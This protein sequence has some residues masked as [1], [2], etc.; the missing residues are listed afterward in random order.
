MGGGGC[1]SEPVSPFG[2]GRGHGG[3][4]AWGTWERRRTWGA[5]VQGDTGTRGHRGRRP[6]GHPP[7]G[8]RRHPPTGGSHGEGR[9]VSGGL[10]SDP[11]EEA[12]SRDPEPRPGTG[13][14][15]ETGPDRGRNPGT[16]PGAETQDRPGKQDH[17]PARERDPAGKPGPPHDRTGSEARGPTG[18]GPTTTRWAPRPARHH[19]ARPHRPPPASSASAR[20]R[21]DRR[22]RR[23]SRGRHRRPAPSRCPSRTAYTR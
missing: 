20:A 11:E 4:R 13:P 6:R 2:R 22:A 19:Q 21:R 5:P 23:V 14:G 12:G 15:A 7:T 16:G 9:P 1:T 3:R 18:P 8:T 17:R 10:G